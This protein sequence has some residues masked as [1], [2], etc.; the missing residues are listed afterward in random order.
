LTGRIRGFLAAAAVL[1]ASLLTACGGTAHQQ[2]AAHEPA[3]TQSASTSSPAQA[4][5][6]SSAPRRALNMSKEAI[7]HLPRLTIHRRSGT[8]PRKLVVR[9][10][11]KGWGARVRA[12]DAVVVRYF[13]VSY[14]T[15]EKKSSAGQFG[16]TRFGMNEVIKAWDL[17]LP[18]MRVGGR[19]ELIVPPQVHF[20]KG[21]GKVGSP[22]WTD[23][24]VID[25]LGVE[26]GGAGS[27]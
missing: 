25:L 10:I 2:S 5:R 24:Y 3:P 4:E 27:L 17:G 18:G 13:E 14:A 8:P 11:R 6:K 16:P 19:R 1:A 23:I 9:D 15:A 26:P 7:A 21:I 20:A 12:D 22:H